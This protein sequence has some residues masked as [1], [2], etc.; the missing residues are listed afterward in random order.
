MLFCKKWNHCLNINNNDVKKVYNKFFGGVYI[1]DKLTWRD[2]ISN[3]R[4]KTTMC[5]AIFNKV[6]YRLH[7]KSNVCFVLCTDSTTPNILCWVVGQ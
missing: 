1:D 2:H 3:V 5:I 7:A 4:K 6:K